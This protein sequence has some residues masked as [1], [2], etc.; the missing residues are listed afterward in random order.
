LGASLLSTAA[1]IAKSVPD[2]WQG[3]LTVAL[4]SVLVAR[5]VLQP[6]SQSKQHND[7]KSVTVRSKL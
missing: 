4:V 2:Q 5:G 7:K 1:W 3:L 6:T